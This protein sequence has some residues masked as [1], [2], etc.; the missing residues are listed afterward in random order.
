MSS[1][2]DSGDSSPAPHHPSTDS[3]LQ[4]VQAFQQKTGDRPSSKTMVTALVQAEKH[5]KQHR[6]TYSVESLLG[7]WRFRFG[8][9]RKSRNIA[10]VVQGSGFYVP[11]WINAT[12]AFAHTPD[13]KSS[14][15]STSDIPKFPILTIT[16]ALQL[17]AVRLQLTGPAKYLDGKN[18]MAFDFHQMEVTV[19]RK[20][21]Y[22]G[23]L[24]GRSPQTE[25]FQ[26]QA[27]GKLPFFAFIA[28]T[29][30]YIAARGRGGGLALW[31]KE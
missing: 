11:S 18:L 23:A 30:D 7:T 17:G 15:P 9:S 22:A 6:N 19:G 5:C 24:P 16:N 1:N 21:L 12:L 28:A 20:Q 26:Q 13:S 2:L 4:A 29:D 3:L 25:D 27:I 31:S 8:A 10:G 14:T